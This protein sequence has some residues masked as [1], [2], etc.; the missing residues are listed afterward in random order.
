MSSAPDPSAAA[1]EVFADGGGKPT[2]REWIAEE[3]VAL[4][5]NGLSYAVMMATPQGLEDFATGFALSEGLAG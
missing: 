2:C 3:P 4:E 5:Y 1:T